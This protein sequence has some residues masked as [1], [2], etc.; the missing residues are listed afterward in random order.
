[1]TIH[2]NVS[3]KL[4]N[5]SK[6]IGTKVLFEKLT[7][8]LHPGQ[9]LVITGPNGSGKSTLLKMIAGLVRATT[10]TIEV[11]HGQRSLDIEERMT[12]LGMVSPEIMFYV[13][14]TGAENILFFAQARGQKCSSRELEECFQVV[15]LAAYKDHLVYTYSTGMRQRLKF[16]LML[17]SKPLLWLLDEPSSNL[18]DDGKQII[19]EMISNGLAK[20]STLIIGTNESWEAE[21]ANY[22]IQLG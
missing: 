22:K 10:G 17:I 13:E 7:V 19:R 11:F 15:G 2:Q 12:C 16:A 9:C 3:V 5:V 14:M 8:L 21:Y 6:K 20:Q 1:M 4:T 18:D